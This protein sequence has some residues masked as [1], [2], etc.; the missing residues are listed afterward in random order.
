ML[1]SNSLSG[2]S[3]LRVTLIHRF[4]T[5]CHTH[6]LANAIIATLTLTVAGSDSLWIFHNCRR[7]LSGEDAQLSDS[8]SV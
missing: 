6:S 2:V 4:A 5:I 7:L 8:G 3:A 1:G